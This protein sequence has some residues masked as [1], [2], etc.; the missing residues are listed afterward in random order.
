MVTNQD[1]LGTRAFPKKLFIRC[2][3]LCCK[4]LE[5]E[6]IRFFGS[7][8]LTAV[9]RAKIADAQTR[10]GNAD[11]IFF[12]RIRFEKFVRHRRPRNRR[13]VGEKFGREGDFYQKPNFDLPE[14]KTFSSRKL[15]RD[16]RIFK[17]AAAPRFAR[18][19]DERNRNSSN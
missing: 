15:A 1:G 14:T 10:N 17:T 13:S 19:H 9:S 2:R 4:R 12:R 5:N 8:A 18:A 11:E 7:F 6:G 16:L 3:I